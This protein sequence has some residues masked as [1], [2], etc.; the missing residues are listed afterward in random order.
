MNEIYLDNAAT[1]KP[2]ECVAQKVYETM[3]Q[4]YG[5]PSSLHKK[6][7]EAENSIKVVSTFLSQKL[8]CLPEEIIYTSG[9]TESNNMALLGVCDAYKRRAN[10]IITTPLEHPSVTEVF[11]E[12]EKK[13][14][15]VHFVKVDEQGYVQLEHL[16]SLLDDKTLLVSIMH[17]NNEIGTVQDIELLGQLIKAQNKEILFHVDAVQSFMKLPIQ[18]KKGKIDLLSVSAH[19]FYGPRGVG[20]LYKNKN[21]RMSS[22]L[23]GG[24]QQKNIRSGTE[25]VPG[26][27]GLYE[28]CKYMSDHD[29]TII[30]HFRACK[31]YLAEGILNAIPDTFINGPTIEEGA[32][33]IL[34]ISF[35]NIRAEVLLHALEQ[36][37]VYVSSG[38]ACSSHKKAS[39]GTLVAIGKTAG[40]LDSALRFSFSHDTTFKELDEVIQILMEQVALL[41]RYT[42]GGNKK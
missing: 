40:H 13:S 6:G 23:Y 34:N 17:V 5:N 9:A 38:S 2:L 24:G 4:T 15:E 20:F 30:P 31:K 27:M 10:K 14:F 1:T 8:G 41:R 21:I 3:L 32:P 29:K 25:N 22:L 42:L 16:K 37:G 18:V 19:K 36:K 26:I 11:K 28:A 35:E 12:L 7:I 33:H 39:S